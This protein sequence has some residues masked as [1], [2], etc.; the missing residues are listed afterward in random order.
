[1]QQHFKHSFARCAILVAVGI[2]LGYVES[3]IFPQ[4]LV[5]GIKIGISNIVVLF[6]LLYNGTKEAI[7]IGVL[8][9]VLTGMI[10]SSVTAI[11]YSLFG[12]FLSVFIMSILKKIFYD[13]YIS[14]LG[15]SIA[16][17]AMFNLGQVI[18]AC[19]I[20]KSFHCM[21]LLSYMLPFSVI[22]G[23]VTGIIVQLIFNKIKRGI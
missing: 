3:I 19:V 6:S 13:K 10:F 18:I 23:I 14:V 12:I 8:K 22:T 15:I 5:Y 1:M 11:I 4:G 17:S 2:V 21:F 16:G 7:L 20:T 9:S